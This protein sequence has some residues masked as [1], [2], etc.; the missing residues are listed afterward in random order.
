ML[1]MEGDIGEIVIGGFSDLIIL[2]KNPLED[3]TVLDKGGAHVKA[4]I[5][6]GYVFKRNSVLELLFSFGMLLRTIASLMAV[7]YPA[8]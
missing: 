5:K 6:G 3:I 2:D 7:G 1:K 8:M 4:V